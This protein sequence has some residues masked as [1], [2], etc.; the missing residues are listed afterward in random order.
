M[1]FL[2]VMCTICIS[3]QINP[4]LKFDQTT[5]TFLAIVVCFL[6]AFDIIEY[7]VNIKFKTKKEKKYGKF[8]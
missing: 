6:L 3:Q 5:S 1:R 8:I 4:N 7:C 2:L